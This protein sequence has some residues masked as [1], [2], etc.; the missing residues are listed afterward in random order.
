MCVTSIVEAGEALPEKSR[1]TVGRDLA[2]CSEVLKA[3]HCLEDTYPVASH[4][5]RNLPVTVREATPELL[6]LLEEQMFRMARNTA[7]GQFGPDDPP[8][9]SYSSRPCVCW[10]TSPALSLPT[11]D[12][13]S[14]VAHNAP[15]G[16]RAAGG[17]NPGLQG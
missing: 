12:Q 14:L 3:L 11:L 9:R 2:S 15:D 16:R 10:K 17:K 6:E 5:L 4:V 7:T 1:N 13:D 8:P